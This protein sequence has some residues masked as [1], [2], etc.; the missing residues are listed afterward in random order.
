MTA[1]TAPGTKILYFQHA[2]HRADEV[3]S[4]RYY[5]Y[6]MADAFFTPAS[7]TA[8]DGEHVVFSNQQALVYI[9]AKPPSLDT[10]PA[11]A[12][13]IFRTEAGSPLNTG[14]YAQLS[15][16]LAAYQSQT[17]YVAFAEVDNQYFL[18]FGID[19]IQITCGALVTE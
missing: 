4:F 6:N 9:S 2:V 13:I 10:Y 7:F 8:L 3:L 1:Q 12:D 11:A 17:I 15:T 5:V 18:L 19:D 16:S 14:V